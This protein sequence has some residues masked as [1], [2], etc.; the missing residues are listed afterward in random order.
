MGMAVWHLDT[1]GSEGL[2]LHYVRQKLVTNMEAQRR[3]QNQDQYPIANMK[4]EVWVFL[5]YAYEK[6]L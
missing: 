1:N 4:E 5:Q 6:E 2:F 3:G